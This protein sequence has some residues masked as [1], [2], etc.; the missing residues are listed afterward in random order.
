MPAE[1]CPLCLRLVEHPQ[2][3]GV[4]TPGA[5]PTHPGAST[6]IPGALPLL[7]GCGD[8]SGAGGAVAWLPARRLPPWLALPVTAVTPLPSRQLPRRARGITMRIREL[9]RTGPPHRDPRGWGTACAMGRG[10]R[11][12]Q[13]GAE[14][15]RGAAQRCH[16]HVWPP[17]PLAG[18]SHEDTSEVT[19]ILLGPCTPKTNIGK[20]HAGLGPPDL[21][22]PSPCR[23]KVTPK[24]P[25]IPLPTNPRAPSRRCGS[26]RVSAVLAL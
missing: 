11:C 14:S 2:P 25:Q 16:Q 18:H 12:P 8:G 20:Q 17:C 4:G 15:Q 6:S 7:P 9:Q 23:A 10:G 21:S 1:L 24:I 5:T 26:G 19:S 22:H 3:R 13:R